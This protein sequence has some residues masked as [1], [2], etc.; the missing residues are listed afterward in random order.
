MIPSPR[1]TLPHAPARPGSLDSHRGN[2][3]IEAPTPAGE[4]RAYAERLVAEGVRARHTEFPSL[5]HGFALMTGA[6]PAAHRAM[7]EIFAD[8]GR[9]LRD[10]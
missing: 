3:S 2:A 10:R 4:G 9:A 5:I 6:L 1:L 7:T 8:V